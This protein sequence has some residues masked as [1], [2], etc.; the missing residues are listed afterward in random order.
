MFLKLFLNAMIM[1]IKIQNIPNIIGFFKIME[2]NKCIHK[3]FMKM[4]I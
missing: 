2:F 1:N 3:F 4:F